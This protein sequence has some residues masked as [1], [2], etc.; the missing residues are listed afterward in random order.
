MPSGEEARGSGPRTASHRPAGGRRNSQ[1]ADP[2][3]LQ[4]GCRRMVRERSRDPWRRWPL[5]AH[6]EW[7]GRPQRLRHAL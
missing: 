3:P 4:G 1:P 7:Q 6:P 5:V 2:L